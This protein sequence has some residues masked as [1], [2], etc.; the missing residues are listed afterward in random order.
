[1]KKSRAVFLDRDGVLIKDV[2]LIQNEH[3]IQILPGVPEA[4]RLLKAASFLLITVSNQ[5]AIAR[6]ILNE[7]SVERLNEKIEDDLIQAGAPPLD[8]FYYCPHH[9]NADLE[10]YRVDCDCR[11][12]K[13]GLI[14][15]AARD[16]DAALENSIMVGDRITDI[17]A[18]AAAGCRTVL[19]ETGHHM[20][21]P[22]QTSEPLDLSI[23]PDFTCRGL[24]EAARWILEGE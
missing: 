1:V 10:V 3:D 8:G 6:G 24:L 14:I 12:P 2:N 9:P 5:T 4:L 15:R 21:P 16:H 19:V 22:I 23:K 20:E 7:Q 11:K 18:G 17:I 13:P